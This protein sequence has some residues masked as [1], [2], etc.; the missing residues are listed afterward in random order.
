MRTFWIFV[1]PKLLIQSSIA[2]HRVKLFSQILSHPSPYPCCCWKV[3]WILAAQ[4]VLA[5]PSFLPSSLTP[6][7]LPSFAE[8]CLYLSMS[9]CLCLYLSMSIYLCLYLSMSIYLSMFIS[10]YLLCLSMHLSISGPRNE[11]L[12]WLR[13]GVEWC[14]SSREERESALLFVLLGTSVVCVMPPT[15]VRVDL[16][17]SVHWFK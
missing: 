9:V 14:P 12:W 16:L 1:S 4:M 3:A 13:T 17:Y 6:L 7:P 5:F 10:I 2:F 11:E 15:L 8:A